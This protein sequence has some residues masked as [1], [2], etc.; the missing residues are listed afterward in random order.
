MLDIILL[1]IIFITTFIAFIRGFIY[2]VFSLLG[3]VIAIVLTAHN[4]DIL[5]TFFSTYIHSK[6]LRTIVS[7]VLLY[8][9]LIIVIMIFNIW[10]MHILA[11]LRK[12]AIDRFLG[13]ILGIIKG[14]LYSLLLLFIIE[15]TYLTL[16]PRNI[17]KKYLT[18]YKMEERPLWLSS[19]KGY[20]LFIKMHK[21]MSTL[22]PKDI[23]HDIEK[24]GHSITEKVK[25]NKEKHIGS[26]FLR[27]KHRDR[28]FPKF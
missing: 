6:I 23:Y 12:G 20:I 22:L 7:I 16:T 13:I 8:A 21:D 9:G 28:D 17:Y 11:P 18:K 4:F 2:E 15:V 10:L 19:S 25:T 24:F 14:C 1:T 26:S 3:I 5:S 27:Q